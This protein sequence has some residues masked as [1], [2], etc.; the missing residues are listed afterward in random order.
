MEAVNLI[1]TGYEPNRFQ[2]EIHENLRRFSVLVCHRRFGKTVLA[3]NALIDSAITAE[4][5]DA[6]LAYLAPYLRQA[7][8]VAWGYL[9]QFSSPIPGVKINESELWIEY[10]GGARIR[11]YGADN[12]ES[13]R[14]I[15]LD[16]CV[17]DEVADMRPSVWGEIIRPALSDRKGWCL[18][19]GTPKGL[20]MFSEMYFKALEDPTWYAGLFSVE[21]T[22]HGLDWLDDEELALARST[23]SDAQYRQE[24]L[25]DFNASSENTLIPI[26]VVTAAAGK[27][28][29]LEDYNRAPRVIGVD[30]ARFG[31]D[32]SVIIRRQGLVCFEPKI[33]RDLDNM[34]LAGIV[35]QEIADWKP[36]AVFIDA[37]RGEGVIDRL[38][39][40][41]HLVVEVNF[42]GRANDNQRYANKRAEMWDTLAEWLRMGGALPN[43]QEL[44]SSIVVPT[45]MFDA[46]NRMQLEKKEDIK[47]RVAFSPDPADALALTFAQKVNRREDLDKFPI[48]ANNKYKLFS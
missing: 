24:F 32:R 35:A 27:N 36:D 34:T 41:G 8:D 48:Q 2:L 26:D 29:R 4:T 16:G 40:L 5:R 43:N 46:A 19:N 1:H 33:F 30:V 20:N 7:K 3:V 37:G 28:V 6:R 18:F 17:L 47:K 25:C 9:K 42:G 44:I 12:P 15:Y 23:M 11:V 31:D 39:Q 45:Y 14:G 21:R 22:K 10:P 38:R 13:L